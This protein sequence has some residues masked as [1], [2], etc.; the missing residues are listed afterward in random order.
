MGSINRSLDIFSHSDVADR[1][2]RGRAR[3]VF[4]AV[5][6]ESQFPFVREF[7]LPSDFLAVVAYIA[8]SVW[9]PRM[10]HPIAGNASASPCSSRCKGARTRFTLADFAVSSQ[11]LC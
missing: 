9:R 10:R 6:G 7:S 5:L 11:L 2:Q 8:A 3:Q 4:S 1:Y